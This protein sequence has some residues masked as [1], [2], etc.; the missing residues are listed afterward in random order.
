[1]NF[2]YDYNYDYSLLPIAYCLLPLYFHQQKLHIRGQIDVSEKTIPKE[3]Q[4]SKTLIDNILQKQKL[5][6]C[7]NFL[8][9]DV[10]AFYNGLFIPLEILFS[11]YFLFSNIV[12]DISR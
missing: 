11:D 12:S 7:K 1:M 5:E 4:I 9:W 10:R 2:D 6:M 8:H 3:C